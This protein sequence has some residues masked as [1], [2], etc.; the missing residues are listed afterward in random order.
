[1][2]IGTGWCPFL[3]LVKALQA[4]LSRA[5]RRTII[6]SGTAGV[7]LHESL[8]PVLLEKLKNSKFD[9]LGRKVPNHCIFANID[10]LSRFTYARYPNE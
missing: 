9:A 5:C 3:F 10:I 1:M 4:I 8:C 6:A 2:D 7:D